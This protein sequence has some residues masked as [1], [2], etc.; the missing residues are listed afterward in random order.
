MDRLDI[1]EFE[2]WAKH[3]EKVQKQRDKEARGAQRGR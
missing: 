3:L 1:D 2:A